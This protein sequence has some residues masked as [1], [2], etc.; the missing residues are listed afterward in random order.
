MRWSS[1]PAMKDH[2]APSA[3]VTIAATHNAMDDGRGDP[4][5]VFANACRSER[6]LHN[7]RDK[8]NR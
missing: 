5:R 1:V 2:S 6:R 8:I 4:H 7:S 3:A